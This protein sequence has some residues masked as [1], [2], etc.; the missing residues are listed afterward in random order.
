MYLY[1]KS[2]AMTLCSVTAA[3][4]VVL[5]G[6]TEEPDV[7]KRQYYIWA[8]DKAGNISAAAKVNV[9][10]LDI[11]PPVV[12]KVETQR[13]W[14][15]KGNWAKVTAQDDNNGVVAIGW[16]LK[17]EA[18]LS[19]FAGAVQALQNHQL[20]TNRPALSLGLRLLRHVF[21]SFLLPIQY[22]HRDSFYAKIPG[23]GRGFS[24]DILAAFPFGG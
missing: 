21:Q 16:A 6:L 5:T 10:A 8:A 11:V 14:D 13:T 24:Q 1:T 20:A 7:Y 17:E 9:T 15:A 3:L 18:F 23:L 2:I 12:V 22:A 19:R 4:A